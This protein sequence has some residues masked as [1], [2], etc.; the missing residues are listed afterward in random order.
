MRAVQY[1]PL[2]GVQSRFGGYDEGGSDGDEEMNGTDGDMGE[3]GEDEEDGVND[4]EEDFSPL[5]DN[6]VGDEMDW[7]PASDAE[8]E[9][10]GEDSGDD[11]EDE[12][13]SE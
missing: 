11:N 9:N 4:D 5:G 3:E 1:A 8:G 10:E 13:D 2:A 12:I 7:E 6:Y